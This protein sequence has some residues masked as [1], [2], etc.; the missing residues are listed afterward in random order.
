MIAIGGVMII[1]GRTSVLEIG[2]GKEKV[3]QGKKVITSALVGMVLALTA[4]L[5][6]DAFF[7]ILNVRLPNNS[8][9]YNL[10]CSTIPISSEPLPVGTVGQLPSTKEPPPLPPTLCEDPETTA[11]LNNVP[12]P[13]QNSPELN[14]VIDCILS[15][16]GE[17]KDL[18]DQSQ[19]YTYETSNDLCNYIR[20]RP[21]C[22]P[23]AH[24]P[25]SCH[26]GGGYGKEGAEAVDINAIGGSYKEECRLFN[27]LRSISKI[28]DY[29]ISKTIF[30]VYTSSGGTIQT[31]CDP[32]QMPAGMKSVHTH[33][34]TKNC[35][36][37]TGI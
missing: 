14:R 23:C 24:R 13:R 28:C 10:Q 29:P 11:L 27:W 3:I 9:W 7:T 26:Y 36:T 12:Y 33:I 16:P 17:E 4:F 20:G 35:T 22:G 37:G 15:A 31:S 19:I 32:S 6:V 2:G 18:I 1:I 30:E 8:K 34:S 25:Y 5:I 21:T